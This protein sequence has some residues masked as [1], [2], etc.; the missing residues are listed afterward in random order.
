MKA[1]RD[2]GPHN[3]SQENV[4]VMRVNESRGKLASSAAESLLRPFGFCV[5][6]TTNGGQQ[7]QVRR[8]EKPARH[9][10]VWCSL[11]HEH[12]SVNITLHSPSFFFECDRHQGRSRR[13]RAVE[14]RESRG[15][16]RRS[17]QHKKSS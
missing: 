6:K 4:R 10:S 2:N 5:C 3:S 7:V 11:L 14:R 9:C 1:K 13:L 17:A 12:F 8:Q 15:L 16:V